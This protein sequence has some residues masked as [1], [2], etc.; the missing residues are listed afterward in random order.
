M[1][2]RKKKSYDYAEGM[3]T[4]TTESFIASQEKPAKKQSRTS[5][6]ALDSYMEKKRLRDN[7]TFFEL[8]F[9]QRNSHTG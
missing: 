9:E 4:N 5:R 3:D 1:A 8:D 6:K 7:L 2:G